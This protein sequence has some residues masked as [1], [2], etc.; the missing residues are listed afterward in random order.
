MKT[1]SPT[2]SRTIRM[3]NQRTEKPTGANGFTLLELLMTIAIAGILLAVGLPSFGSMIAESRISAQYNSFVGSLYQARSEAIKGGTDITV[4][5]R[6]AVE[7]TSCGGIGDWKNGWIVFKDQ[8]YS[9]SESVALV[10]SQD[11]ILSVKPAMKGENTVVAFGSRTN[12]VT[13][14][15]D[16]AYVR[17]MQNGS[18]SLSTGSIVI[19]DAGRGAESSRA[20]NVSLTGDIR[21]GSVVAGSLVPR[22]AFNRPVSC[23]EPSN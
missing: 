13:N 20:L 2:P 22:D 5:P 15:A 19:C 16:V 8:A 10:E 12:Q 18:S 21:R 7:A 17:Y 6:S 3:S 4:C 1:N 11:A 9:P 23:P 14:V